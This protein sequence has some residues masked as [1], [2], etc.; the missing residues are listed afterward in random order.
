MRQR[1]SR[2]LT[3]QMPRPWVAAYRVLPPG[4]RFATGRALDVDGGRHLLCGRP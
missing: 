4:A 2:T 3:A 1:R